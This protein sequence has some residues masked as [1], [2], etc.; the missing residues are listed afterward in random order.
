MDLCKRLRLHLRKDR[1]GNII[2]RYKSGNA[3]QPV[4]FTAHMDHP[5]FEVLSV[6]GNEC[7]VGILGGINLE[8][9]RNASVLIKTRFGTI[10]GRVGNRPLKKKWMKKPVF[11]VRTRASILIKRGD[12]GW[13]DL[14]GYRLSKGIVHTKSADNLASTAALLDLLVTLRRKRVRAD[15]RCI[16]T[17][18]E[19]VGFIGCIA[20]S[21]QNLLPKNVPVV[22]LE[23]SSAKAAKVAIGGGPV[24]RVGDKL[25][26]YDPMV[27]SWL[28]AAADSLA[29][30]DKKFRFQRALLG[31]GTCEASVWTIRGRPNG[32]LAFPLGNYH[33][34]G[35]NG[36][37][38][39]YISLDDY[40]LMQR[41]LIEITVSGPYKGPFDASARAILKNY[42]LWE[43]KLNSR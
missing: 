18:S 19:E 3:K 23:C 1:Y 21:K 22:V 30:K 36:Y 25:S 5:G 17:R 16:F 34:N 37:A 9:F 40:R 15:V 24:V 31:G 4:I 32:G 7:D 6:R 35:R 42:R 27:D 33:N 26:C 38:A 11:P 10:K 43:Q 39:E 13:F 12:F 2:V 28:K 14:P 20:L 8:H 41:L 29:K